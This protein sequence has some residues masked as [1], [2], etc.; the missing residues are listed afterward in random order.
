MGHPVFAIF[1]FMLFSVICTEQTDTSS[2][3]PK[4]NVNINLKSEHFKYEQDV[5]V[6]I[7]LTNKTNS[8][9]SVWFDKPI[10]STGGP[11]W[12]TINLTNKKTGSSILKYQNKAILSSQLYSTE[13]VKKFS[14]Q[15]KPGEKVSG[16]FSLYNLVVL[17][18]KKEKLDIGNYEIQVHYCSNPSNKLSFTVR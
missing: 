16:Q 17:S 4:V 2:M 10:T 1:L 11:A 3:C 7:T 6:V 15:L 14:Y 5:I 12:T 18:D 9:Q 13:E 8:I